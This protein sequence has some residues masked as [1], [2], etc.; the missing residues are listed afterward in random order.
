[1]NQHPKWF[2]YIGVR[3]HRILGTRIAPDF[4]IAFGPT[5]IIKAHATADKAERQVESIRHWIWNHMQHEESRVI[6]ELRQENRLLWTALTNELPIERVNA[7]SDAVLSA[8]SVTPSLQK[9]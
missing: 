5:N 6:E 1:M 9:R 2:E 7:L 8:R 4:V 3:E